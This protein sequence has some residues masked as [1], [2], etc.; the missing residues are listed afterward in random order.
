MEPGFRF[1]LYL[2]TALMLV[3]CGALLTRLYE[4]QIER[5]NEFL[6]QMP[7]NRTVTVREPGIRGEITDRNGVTLARNL[8]KYEVSF[9]LEEIRSAYLSQ[10]VSDPTIERVTQENGL[11]R[12]R[13]EKDIVAIVN[14]WVIARLKQPDL[15]LARNYNARAL[16]THY[17]THGGLIPFSYRADLTST[18]SPASPNTTSNSPA[19]ISPCGRN[20][21]IRMVRSPATSSAT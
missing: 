20:A 16:R 17:L 5:R 21:S 8:R 3:G 18:S 14:D 2:L 19:S 11:P 9:N 12:K 1:R 13:S 15:D 7:G 10:H 6:N 4:F